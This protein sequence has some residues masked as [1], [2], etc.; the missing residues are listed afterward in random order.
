MQDHTERVHPQAHQ[1]DH[2]DPRRNG[3]PQGQAGKEVGRGQQDGHFD[4]QHRDGATKCPAATARE[5]GAPPRSPA[6]TSCSRQTR[7]LLADA[8]AS[9]HRHFSSPSHRRLYSTNRATDQS[10][11]DQHMESPA[12]NGAA[13]SR[14]RAAR[15]ASGRAPAIPARSVA[16]TGPRCTGPT[17]IDLEYFVVPPRAVHHPAMRAVAIPVPRPASHR[18]GAPPFYPSDYHAY[19]ENHGRLARLLVEARARSRARFYGRLIRNRPGRIFDVGT[20]DCRHFDELRRFLDLECAGIEI[21]PDIAAKGRA[22]GYDVLEGTLETADLTDHLGRYDVVSMNHVLEHVVYPHTMLERARTSCVPVDTSSA[23]CP[24]SRRG[25]TRSSGA[26]GAATTTRVTSRSRRRTGP[27]GSPRGRR[28][29]AGHHPVGAPHPDHHLPAE[30]ARPTGMA[31][32]HAVTARRRLLRSCWSPPCRTRPS[33]GSA[34]R[35]A[36][37]TS[38]AGNPSLTLSEA[39]RRRRTGQWIR[40]WHRVGWGEL[41]V[42]STTVSA[43]A[44][45][46]E[47]EPADVDGDGLAA[48]QCGSTGHWPVHGHLEQVLDRIGGHHHRVVDARSS[49]SEATATIGSALTGQDEGQPDTRRGWP[50]ARR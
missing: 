26:T 22:R 34:T 43:R 36:S 25:R 14:T 41:A 17:S 37:S 30:H 24:R 6:R 50:P 46:L 13:S 1:D 19:N 29:R 15:R 21:Q 20:G 9:L 28:V 48:Q 3:P 39:S 42:V 49:R 23:S 18:I 31:T 33:P 44:V 11:E 45:T 16:R 40:L 27:V 32:P 5:C 10:E 4:P 2:D 38:R 12:G 35:G 8:S 7:S 47:C